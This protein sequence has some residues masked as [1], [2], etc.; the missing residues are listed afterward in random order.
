MARDVAPGAGRRTGRAAGRT[1][2]RGTLRRPVRLV[3]QLLLLIA[4]LLVWE[5]LSRTNALPVAFVGRPSEYLV[6]FVDQTLN[7]RFPKAAAD[8]M[9]ATLIAFVIGG[10]AAIVSALILTALPAVREITGPYV[11]ALNSLPRVALIPLFIVWFGLGA[12]AKIASG[13]SLMYF[14]LLYNTL[15][16]AQS[17]DP[18]HL[19]LARTLGLPGWKTFGLIVIPTAMPSIFAGLRLGMIYTLLGV[20]TAEL[21]AGGKGLGSLVSFY[22][23]TYNANGVFAVLVFLVILAG[24]LSA[25]MTAIERK[26]GEWQR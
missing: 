25:L 16:G 10:A 14:V 15:A 23:N 7:G 12:T 22:S 1:E 8:T 4:V 5:V 24:I 20:V 26:L 6:F 2:R 9:S 19:Q 13:V 11:T 3:S 21:I 17:V 18:D